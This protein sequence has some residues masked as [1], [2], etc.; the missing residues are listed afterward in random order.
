MILYKIQNNFAFFAFY[1]FCTRQT[2]FCTKVRTQTVKKVMIKI[3]ENEKRNKF[4]LDEGDEDK[5]IAEEVKKETNRAE[6]YE[7]RYLNNLDEDGLGND[8]RNKFGL[9]EKDEDKYIA[10][11]EKKQMNRTELFKEE[12]LN[13]LDED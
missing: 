4:G 5:D 12:D 10:E 11:E 7:E 8:E 3:V 1:V 2:N 9:D 6:L 13:E